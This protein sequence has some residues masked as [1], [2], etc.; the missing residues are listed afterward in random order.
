MPDNPQAQPLA[1]RILCA[2]AED[3]AEQKDRLRSPATTT[4]DTLAGATAGMPLPRL[5]KRLNQSASVLVREL[6]HLS[7]ATVAGQRGPGWVRVVQSEGRWVVHITA[8]GLALAQ[9]WA[10]EGGTQGRG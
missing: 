9:E 2:L 7:D 4:F 10:A 5:A 1:W 8:E 3:A 6:T